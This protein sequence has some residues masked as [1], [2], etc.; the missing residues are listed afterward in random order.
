MKSTSG[1]PA[2]RDRRVLLA[3]MLLAILLAACGT[4]EVS[5]APR[6]VKIGLV[7]PFEG[8]YREIGSDVIPAVRTAILHYTAARGPDDPVVEL[9]AFDDGG[10]PDQAVRQ[11]EAVMADAEVAAVIGHWRDDTTAAAL[12]IYTRRGIPAVTFSAG[13]LGA[14]SVYN[15][16]PSVA[17]LRTAADEA[18]FEIPY[19][20]TDDVE[21]AAQAYRAGGQG[22]GEP[23]GWPVW[24]LS[25]FFSLVEPISGDLLYVTG[26]G[27]P[28]DSAAIFPD[29]AGL[30]S[31]EAG[32]KA[33]SLGAPPGPFSAVAYQAAWL[34]IR[35]ALG[36]TPAGAPAVLVD[37]TF[38]QQGR[39]VDPPVYVYR[40]DGADRLLNLA[41]E[42]RI[43]Q[44]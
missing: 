20:Y 5:P 9:V 13:D 35:L 18:G 21:S 28:A 40:W 41:I 43:G 3:V 25:Q 32:Y 1:M 30:D 36:E 16:S 37:M 38:D 15:L 6:V 14:G 26:A 4:G 19:D 11:A 39:L 27:L 10:E 2:H 17:Q 24:G 7:A 42:A 22:V 31:F 23:A 33:S 12:P 34:A 29:S 44:P 8:R